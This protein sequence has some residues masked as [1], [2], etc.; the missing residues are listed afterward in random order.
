MIPAFDET[1]NLPRGIHEA[2]WDEVM[3]RLGATPCRRGLLE[4]SLPAF[5]QFQRAGCRS[6]YL[7]GSFATRKDCPG[8]IDV[9]WDPDGVDSSVLM[10]GD[11]VLGDSTP[12]ARLLQTLRFGAEFIPLDVPRSGLPFLDFFQTVKETDAP[13]GIVRLDLQTLP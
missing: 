9:L 1:G 2:P 3:S 7:A 11:P 10:T 5:R 6:L 12:G 8:D 4:R 13:R